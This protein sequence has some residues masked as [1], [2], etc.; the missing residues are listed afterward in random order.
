MGSSTYAAGVVAAQLRARGVDAV[1]EL[2]SSDLLPPP[3]PRTLVV[4]ISA[5]GGSRETLSATSPY[6][7]RAPLVAVT[8]VEVRRSPKARISL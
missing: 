1:A 6:A 4:A 5:S 2:A 8:N 7:G 3:D